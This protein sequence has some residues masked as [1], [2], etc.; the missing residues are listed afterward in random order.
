MGKSYRAGLATAGFITLIFAAGFGL[1]AGW[2]TALWPVEAGRLSHIFV[3][4]ILGAIGGPL[5]WIAA[6]NEGR[7]IAAGAADLALSNI[8]LAVAGFWFFATTGNIGMLILGIG[9]TPLA[10]LCIW[11]FIRWH[12]VPYTNV[13][14]TPMPVRIAFGLFAAALVFVT[15]R[16]I[17]VT[18][19][20]FP[21]PLGPENSVI[22]GCF[23]LGAMVYFIYGLC[24]PVWGNAGGQL[25]GFLIYDLMLIIPFIQH[26]AKVQPSSFLSLAVYTS[27][28]AL[29][30]L[31]AA[32]Y[33]F[34]H[35]ATRFGAPSSQAQPR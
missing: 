17:L 15:I 23:F 16:L 24:Y 4:S 8:G 13:V 21:W 33:L 18:N 26:F 34:V 25:V 35:P 32:W 29:S 10:L 7:A 31:L 9:A 30:G 1:Q 14:P 28:V 5:I 27:V 22:Y 2:A 6:T 3:G 19:Y 11:L 12:P 20:T